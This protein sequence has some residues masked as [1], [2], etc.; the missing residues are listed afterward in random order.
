MEQKS[1]TTR[2][3]P[4]ALLEGKYGCLK[5]GKIHEERTLDMQIAE[6]DVMN[7]LPQIDYL[8]TVAKLTNG[9]S[10][11]IDLDSEIIDIDTS[12]FDQLYEYALSLKGM[13]GHITALKIWLG[14]DSNLKV[15][16]LFQ[17]VCANFKSGTTYTVSDYN[18]IYYYDENGS[19]GQMFQEYT[20]AFDLRENYRKN[21]R[22]KHAGDT[23]FKEFIECDDTE[24]IIYPFQ[25]IYTLMYDNP[26][27]NFVT[28]KNSIA[29]TKTGLLKDQNAILLQAIKITKEVTESFAGK[30]ANRSHLCPPCREINDFDLI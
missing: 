13:N 11:L 12:A 24:A 23:D 19:P 27:A 14:L 6:V 8:N 15:T 20:S 9:N 22:I 3:T 16:P 4:Y 25:T 5:I 17:P 28:L 30:Y 7:P 1:S 10:V 29:T 26:K 18:K 2:R 21:I